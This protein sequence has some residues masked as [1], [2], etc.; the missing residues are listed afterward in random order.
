MPA[1]K[2][3]AKRPVKANKKTIP[4]AKTPPRGTTKAP[5]ETA[6][7][8]KRRLMEEERLKTRR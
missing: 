8:R 5:P 7:E 4:T 6:V 2:A 3:P 1:K